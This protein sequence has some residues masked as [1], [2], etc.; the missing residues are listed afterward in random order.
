MLGLSNDAGARI[1]PISANVT[2][3]DSHAGTYSA[4]CAVHIARCDRIPLEYVGKA[5]S[6]DPT[7]NLVRYDELVPTGGTFQAK[8]VRDNVEALRSRDDWFRPVFLADGPDG[9]LYVV[10]MYR[11]VIEHPEYLPDEVRKNTDFES[12][13]DMGRIWR[14][15]R[16]D[17][18]RARTRGGR[19]GPWSCLRTRAM[20]TCSRDCA[21]T[22]GGRATPR[23][24]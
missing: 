11:K 6:C 12:G 20:T 1:F 3:A 8:R 10:D 22:T 14:I 17:R 5:W 23:S 15:V 24:G 2:T 4:A 9:A 18:S 19:K 21:R 13:R 16:A 7:G